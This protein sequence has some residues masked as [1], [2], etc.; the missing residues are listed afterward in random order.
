MARE[1]L[2]AVE[3]VRGSGLGKGSAI[4]RPDAE[5]I[6]SADPF[7]DMPL[8]DQ[9]AMRRCRLS[10]ITR[11]PCLNVMGV[12]QAVVSRCRWS[13]GGEADASK[14]IYSAV[15]PS[16]SFRARAA[17]RQRR[18]SNANSLC[19]G[20]SAGPQQIYAMFQRDSLCRHF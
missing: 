19:G 4:K 11:A 20:N 15:S 16:F 17:Y 5:I 2:H 18:S 6:L 9:E 13:L 12:S 3:R 10:S 7:L 8:S 1:S 14:M